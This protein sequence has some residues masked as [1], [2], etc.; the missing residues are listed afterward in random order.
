MAEAEDVSISI[1]GVSH[2]VICGLCKQPIAFI[3]TADANSGDAGCASC[4]NIASVSE[5]AQMAVDYAKDEAQLMVNR[6][7]Q[8]VARQSKMM[9]FKG[10][11]AHSKSHRFMVEL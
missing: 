4:D 3:G 2:P 11:T 6:M 8:D 9:S 7:A 10:P 5:V 1:N